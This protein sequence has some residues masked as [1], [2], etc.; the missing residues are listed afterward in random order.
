MEA[1][2]VL[3]SGL[4]GGGWGEGKEMRG[5]KKEKEALISGSAADWQYDVYG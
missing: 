2:V 4:G 5:W 3:V 1:L